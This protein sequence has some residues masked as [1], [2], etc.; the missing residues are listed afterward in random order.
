MQR[1]TSGSQHYVSGFFV[2]LGLS[3]S[4]IINRE[5]AKKS[6]PEAGTSCASGGTVQRQPYC[7]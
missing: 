3:F 2:S 6:L 7:V 5:G 4:K 1:A